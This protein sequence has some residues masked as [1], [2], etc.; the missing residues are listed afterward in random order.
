MK[1]DLEDLEDALDFYKETH[2]LPI[3]HKA[4]AEKELLETIE[5][6]RADLMAQYLDHVVEIEERNL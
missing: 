2:Y 4:T 1:P 5:T 3:G 6:F